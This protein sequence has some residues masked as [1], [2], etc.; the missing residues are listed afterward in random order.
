MKELDIG[1]VAKRA[2]VP[3]ST[4]RFYEKKGLIRPIGRNGLRRQYAESV[5]RTLDLIA[6]G[7][8]AGFTLNEIATM[9]NKDGRT[10]IDPTRL[11]QQAH[12]IDCTIQ[13]LQL[14]SRGLR[15]IAR[16]TAPEHTECDQFKQTM[17]RGLRLFRP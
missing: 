5:L 15:H 6:M 10:A 17:A 4:L 7:Q 13:R 14:L 1:D 3:A 12:H 8:V 2:G 16:C 11:E 9:L